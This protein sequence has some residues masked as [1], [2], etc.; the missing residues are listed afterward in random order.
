[1]TVILKPPPAFG[2]PPGVFFRRKFEL[3]KMRG[4][5]EKISDAPH[6]LEDKI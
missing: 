5:A 3:T 4:I 1:M 6:K 2:C